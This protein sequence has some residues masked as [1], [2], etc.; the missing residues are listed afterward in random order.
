MGDENPIRTI[1]D[2]SK[3]SH[4]GY[5]KT[6]ELLVGNN[7]VPLRSDTIRLV[8]NGCS[9]HG[10]WSEDPNQHL[11]DF[12]KL[13]DSLDLDGENRER[14]RL[15]ESLYDG[16]NHF[17]EL[18]LKVPHHGLDLWLQVQIFYAHVDITTQKGIDYA[19]GGRLRKLRLDEAWAAIERLAQYKDIRWNDTLT[20]DEVNLNFEN[21]NIE[22][23]LGIMKR[24]F[25]TLMMDAISLMKKSKS[26]SRLTTNKIYRPPSEPSCQEEFKHIVTNFILDQEERI[27]QLENVE[28]FMEFSSKVERRLKERIKENK[29]KP[30][31]IEKITRYPDIED[32]EPLNECK[33]SKTLTKKASFHTSKF[34]SPKLLYVKHV[35]TIFSSPPLVR[36]STFGFKPGL[37]LESVASQDTGLSKFKADFKQQQQSEMTNKMETMLKV[38][39][40]QISGTLPS[41]MFKNLKLGTH[42]V[43]SARS[44]P[45][46]NPQCSCHPSN[47]INAI[48]THFKEANIS[49][50][51]LHQPEIKTE[52][53][54]P[55]EP[56]PTLEDEFQNF[57]LN[58]LVL[59]VLAHASTYNAI[60]DKYA[61]SLELGKN[62]SAFIQGEMPTKREDPELFTLPC[63]LGDLKP[64]DSLADLGSCMNIIPLYLFKKLNIGL[65]KETDHVFGL[66][67]ETKSY[68]VRIV[69]GVEVHIGKLKLLNDFYALD[70]KRI[71]SYRQ[72]TSSSAALESNS[73]PLHVSSL[74]GAFFFDTDTP[75]VSLITTPTF[76][77]EVDFLAGI[78]T[79]LD[80][81]AGPS[82]KTGGNLF[83]G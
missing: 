11:K 2:Y 8:Q 5:R 47:S 67:D 28:E 12:L 36:E 4:E 53:P 62:G 65:S 34:V 35:C 19:A 77:I 61:E 25:D 75:G 38:I 54:Q 45:A 51:S 14:T 40:I 64:F 44:Y 66:A 83:E 81:F 42:L 30:R 10:L 49:Q 31:K 26:V 76:G 56:K 3:P 71:P 79:R 37:V 22:Q 55:K 73:I 32:L 72:R 39:T 59:E 24:K 57:H 50:P 60:L 20:P 29:N 18:L 63:R 23:L 46:I 68:P 70:M 6:I 48:K 43:L 27:T 52:P 9:F 1:R 33:F 78:L 74:A 15:H 7:V 16:W 80:F 21:P 13:V 82:S 69:K 41:D 17:K 58:L